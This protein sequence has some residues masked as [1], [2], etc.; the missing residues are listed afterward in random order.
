MCIAFFFFLVVQQSKS[1]AFF[2]DR[3]ESCGGNMYIK[4]PLLS[5]KTGKKDIG[6]GWVRS[7]FVLVRERTA[8]P[9]GAGK[10]NDWVACDVNRKN[11]REVCVFPGGGVRKRRQHNKAD[12]QCILRFFSPESIYCASLK[13]INNKIANNDNI[14]MLHNINY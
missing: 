13:G 8:I 7:G 10:K 4:L 14:R 5:V 9:R 3:V 11:Q 12:D 6:L 1:C 2:M